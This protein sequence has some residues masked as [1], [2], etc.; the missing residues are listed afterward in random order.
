MMK[1]ANRREFLLQAS[2]SLSLG[3]L[4]LKAF[5]QIVL[6]PVQPNL[7]FDNSYA[8]QF[9]DMLVAHLSGKLNALA[10]K[11]DRVRDQVRTPQQAEARHSV[12]R[13]KMVEMI[14]GLPQPTPL[15]PI[16][17]RV[18]ERPGYRIENVMYQSRP[19]FWVTANLYV[20]TTGKGPFPAILS[21]SGHYEDAGRYSAYQ[22]AHL[23]LVKNGFVVLAPDPIGQGERRDHWDTTTQAS[24]G[25]TTDEHSMFGQLLWLIG[26]DVVQYAVW[27]GMR[28]ID[29]LTSRPEV[30]PS[31]IG[32]TGHSGGGLETIWLM[33]FDARVKCAAC[34]EP[35]LYHFWP[36]HIAPGDVLLHGDAEHNV[37]PL[38]L[39]G[40]DI[41]DLY[42][43]F[44]PRPLLVVVETYTN[45]AFQLAS[46][47]VKAHYELF[48]AG[49]KFASVESGEAHYWTVKLRLAATGWFCRWLAE[50]PGPTQE[51]KL[52]IEPT[53]SLFCTPTGSLTDSRQGDSLRSRILKAQ[54]TLPPAREIPK[55]ADEI[56][57]FRQE[58]R[59]LIEKLLH[60]KNVKQPLAVR[61]LK[62]VPGKNFHIEKL[63]F[64][65][66]PG[67]Y[68]PAW[69]FV[70]E[71]PLQ[72]ARPILYIGET[73]TETLGYP[74]SGWGGEMAQ[75]G[76]TVIAVDV[77]GMGQTRPL[78]KPYDES[79]IWTNLFDVETTLAYVAWSMDESLLGM[80]VQ[81]VVHSLDF[82]Q[83]R[84]EVD[85]SRLAVIG[86]GMGALWGLYATALDPRI[87]FLIA[88]GGLLSYKSLAQSGRYKYGA[89]V[90]VRGGLKY[91]DL[92]MIA[93]AIADRNV[94][95]VSPLDPMKMQVPL[96]DARLAYRFTQDT[97]ANAEA[98][99]RFQIVD[100]HSQLSPTARYLALLS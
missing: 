82:A 16:V 49:E 90:F 59:G 69:V 83:S 48:G 15:Q 21:P 65:A 57:T 56:E 51:T 27:D 61:Q 73:D 34:I 28:S 42:Q 98:T 87:Q 31:R 17:T 70:P 13:Q 72:S 68:I 22:A 58:V 93:A 1:T 3:L 46:K 43:S 12:V 81:D 35:A 36:L 11:W 50:H 64:M 30:D 37:F 92:P 26:E 14:G 62:I 95:L 84:P 80:R 96:E 18:L 76:H 8:E 54:E 71:H 44:A 10:E 38:A 32:C 40:I 79:G 86:S 55:S 24:W 94:R 33:V 99:E 63:E 4:P 25:S 5:S 88:D 2:V 78:H 19:N 23:D 100:S 85:I 39:N 89:N 60:Y 77:R 45:Q 7:M 74:E 47:H 41:C 29:Y 20:P 52:I 9:P 67:I 6:P 66:E 91:F 75:Q 53:E 97:Y